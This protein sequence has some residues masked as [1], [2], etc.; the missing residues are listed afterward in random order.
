[1]AADPLAGGLDP[2]AAARLAVG[3]EHLAERLAVPELL[4]HPERQERRDLGVAVG[5][6]HQH[7]A[8]VADGVVLD[9]VHVAQAPERRLVEGLVAE[10]VEV[11]ALE[12]E[13]SD[14]L[15]ERLDVEPHARCTRT[16]GRMTSVR[17]RSVR[18]GK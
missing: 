9:V 6:G 17:A 16:A 3:L 10:R 8:Q 15:L 14:P 7:V 5:V 4:E 18:I 13:R 11:D 12:I 1:M 2:L